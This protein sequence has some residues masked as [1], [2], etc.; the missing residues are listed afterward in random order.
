MDH[1]DTQRKGLVTFSPIQEMAD[2]DI[3]LQIANAFADLKKKK[4]SKKIISEPEAEALVPEVFAP[5]P[6]EAPVGDMFS[7][8]KKKKKKKEIPI[9]LEGGVE[10]AGAS[11][12]AQ[13]D[14]AL[15][16]FGE[17][18]KKKKKT[19]FE[20]FEAQIRAD[21]DGVAPEGNEDVVETKDE[22]AWVSSNRDYTYQ[23]VL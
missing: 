23:E 20:D 5:L 6:E 17:K 7:D 8:M 16:M 2:E 21:E 9:E 14:S 4:K 19:T 18:K 10:E 11:V 13:V 3:E 22:E 15:S 12:D 1:I